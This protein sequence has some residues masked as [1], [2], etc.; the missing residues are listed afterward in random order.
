MTAFRKSIIPE[1]CGGLLCYGA[2]PIIPAAMATGMHW[3]A[4]RALAWSI[5]Q[6]ILNENRVEPTAC[7]R[8]TVFLM[9]FL[10][11]SFHPY[12]L[13]SNSSQRVPGSTFR[14]PCSHFRRRC[15]N[16][17]VLSLPFTPFMFISVPFDSLLGSI[18]A[19]SSQVGGT[20][21]TATCDS[22]IPL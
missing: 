18:F 3:H 1:L 20:G 17:R 15:H 2:M 10:F 6:F 14:G 13:F 22:S 21:R 8:G 9:M 19:P 5:P 4:L 7:E 16:R 11:I 12:T